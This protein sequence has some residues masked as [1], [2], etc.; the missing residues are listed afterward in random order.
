MDPA[1]VE[2]ANITGISLRE[3]LLPIVIPILL[4]VA[5]VEIVHTLIKRK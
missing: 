2:T 3:I 1:I 4:I 5:I